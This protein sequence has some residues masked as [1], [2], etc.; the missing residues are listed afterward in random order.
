MG[1]N[2]HKL[3]LGA[4]T[5]CALLVSLAIPAGA[6]AAGAW[7]QLDSLSAPANLHAGASQS[8]VQEI[9]V[10]AE[11]IVELKVGSQ[12]LGFFV[13]EPY[14]ALFGGALPEPTAANVQ[15][16]LEGA[17]GAGNVSVTGSGPG[18][19]PPLRVTSIGEDANKSV[20]PVT[21]GSELGSASA[22]VL[23]AGH[24]DGKLVV[25]ASN[26]GNAEVDGSSGAPVVLRDK[27]PAGLIA[28][29]AVGL[30]GNASYSPP[31]S[32]RQ[33]FDNSWFAGG[34]HV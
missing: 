8:E 6:G 28:K 19:R 30:A 13:T 12:S 7:W 33:M 25:S 15:V 26:V 14:F 34:M 9:T 17:Y 27:L 20:S 5:A 16:A 23:T 11:A 3:F 21:A 4:V 18:G 29:S 24:S 2:P 22:T 10:S 31:R 1:Y 32:E